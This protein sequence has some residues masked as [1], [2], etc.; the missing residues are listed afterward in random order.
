M[1][2]LILER[3]Y[4]GGRDCDVAIEDGFVQ[5]I[6]QGLA[7]GDDVRVDCSGKWLLPALLDLHVHLR[8]PGGEAKEDIETGCRAAVA[9]GV[10][11]LC[12]MPNTVP[13]PD[14]V[15]AVERLLRRARE[16]GRGVR[17]IPVASAT[18][19]AAGVTPSDYAALRD[20]GCAMVSDDGATI[21]DE[22]V[23]RAC[24]EQC[25]DVGLPFAGHF[26]L[27]GADGQPDEI[28]GVERACSLALETCARVHVLHVSTARA[29]GLIRE[30]RRSGAR[31]TCEVAP[32]HLVLTEADAERLGTLAKVSPRLRT[33]ADCDALVGAVLEGEIDAIASDHAPHTREEKAKAWEAAPPGML[34]ME[35]AFPVAHQALWAAAADPAAWVAAGRAWTRGPW[36][37]LGL[38]APRIEVG[39]EARIVVFAFGPHRVRQSWIHSRSAN[40]PFVGM[41]VRVQP[42]LT[43]LGRRAW[44][45]DPSGRLSPV[46]GG[47]DEG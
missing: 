30:A 2:R 22:G 14:S 15:A 12:P 42:F 27:P 6:G 3:G 16:V 35:C 18:V 47:E 4:V 26:E 36:E 11:G 25:R 10:G 37:V 13:P 33:R 39:A 44:G 40:C 20:A 32:H 45:R 24:L 7:S 5:A 9:G 41:E 43:V 19:R 31:L 34:G 28:A 29:V 17:V 8:E 21:E 1:S 38:P 46:I 23:L